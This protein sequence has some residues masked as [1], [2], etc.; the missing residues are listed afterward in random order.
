MNPN[1][2]HIPQEE[3][4]ECVWH[5]AETETPSLAALVARLPSLANEPEVARLEQEGFLHNVEGRLELTGKGRDLA[6]HVV[7]ANRLAACLL[8]NVLELEQQLVEQHACRLEHAITPELA[9]NLC[10]L[11]GH[12]PTA[13]NGRPIPPGNCCQA[14]RSETAPVIIPLHT[15]EV[16]REGRVAFVRLPTAGQAAPLT[17]YGLAP[18]A[19]VRL[20]QRHPAVV[21]EIGESTLALD[22]EIAAGFYVK[23]L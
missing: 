19:R 2:F 18:G 8:H 10:T 7:R 3:I 14:G 22:T 5:L 6:R 15:L 20:K 21:V 17:A 9:E 4:L 12:P 1:G 11:L 23:P 16:G 13:P